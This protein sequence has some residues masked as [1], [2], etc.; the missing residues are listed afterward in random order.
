MCGLVKNRARRSSRKSPPTKWNPRWLPRIPDQTRPRSKLQTE[1]IPA[2]FS[3]KLERSCR[4]VIAPDDLSFKIKS[5]AVI[6][7]RSDYFRADARTLGSIKPAVRAPT[8][9]VRGGVRIFQSETGEMNCGVAIRNII[10]ILVGPKNEIGRIE[11]PN[12]AAAALDRR[13]HVQSIEKD[14]MGFKCAITIPVFVNGDFVRAPIMFRRGWGDL[15]IDCVELVIEID[16][17][18]ACRIRI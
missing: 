1:R 9:R 6:E 15:V 11:H 7:A 3:E 12:S 18:H 8:K 2:A 16:D 4:R 14:F 13:D 10:V 5:A 17:L